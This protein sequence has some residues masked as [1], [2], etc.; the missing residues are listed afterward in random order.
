MKIITLYIFTM[1]GIFVW[2]YYPTLG[3]CM[4]MKNYLDSKFVDAKADTECIRLG[5][6]VEDFMKE[7]GIL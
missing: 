7:E 5:R 2:D 1:H 4:E 3:A 6:T